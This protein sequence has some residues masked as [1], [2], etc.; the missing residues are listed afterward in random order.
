MKKPKELT[1]LINNYRDKF[2]LV[3]KGVSVEI[4]NLT[5]DFN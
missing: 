3:I 4:I 2:L 1:K 5:K